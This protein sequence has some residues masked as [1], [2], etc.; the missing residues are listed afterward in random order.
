VTV[1]PEKLRIVAQQQEPISRR[2]IKAC[3]HCGLCLPTCPT[4]REL[5]T[6]MDSPRGRIWQMK[7]LTEGKIAATEPE[8]AEHM[9]VCLA[10]RAC[11]TACPSG[12][13]FGTLIEQAR[14]VIPN[15]GRSEEV[16][17]GVLRRVFTSNRRL[18]AL[19][20]AFRAYQRTGLQRA[21]RA[22]RILNLLPR[23][24][25]ELERMTPPMQGGVR[26]PAVPEITPARG[27][28]THRVAFLKGCVQ[29]QFF[30][31]TNQA[32][33]RVLAANGCEV[34]APRRQGCCGALHVHSGLKETAMELAWR[35]IQ[36]FEEAGVEAVIVNVAGCGSVMKEYGLL[37]ASDPERAARAQAFAEK[38]KD[39]SEY[40]A[41]IER[42]PPTRS[43][44]KRVTY[45]D[46]CHLYHGQKVR[47][48]PR[49]LIKSIPGVE[50][51][52]L[53]EADWCCGSAGI[54]NLTKTDL[55][56][57]ILEPKLDYI[58]DTKADILVSGNPGCIMQIR[59][60][61]ER[62]GIPTQVMHIVDLLDLAYR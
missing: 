60:G 21:V 35:N 50:F 46:A 40:L 29:S 45:D 43:V 9:F 62:R 39:V 36:V 37:F 56:L 38:V 55:S 28:R 22:A 61:L 5:G 48:Q 6:E 33:V 59:S 34:V 2:L 15:A 23:R 44:P 25:R 16:G 42:R 8:F 24:L 12:V 18:D 58:A 3:V 10:C 47:L 17:R 4:Y 57:Q 32:T 53:K 54:Y 13:E 26:K 7:L 51:V 11:E 31:E 1:T 41:S 30:G 49:E 27:T 20:F 19:G 52:E 14:A